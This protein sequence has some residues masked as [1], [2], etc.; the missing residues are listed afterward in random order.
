M[1]VQVSVLVV[2]FCSS[3]TSTQLVV[4]ATCEPTGS[5]Q[6]RG[7]GRHVVRYVEDPALRNTWAFF[8]DCDHPEGPGRLV[9]I[10]RTTPRVVN[11]IPVTTT[12]TNLQPRGIHAGETIT[13]VEDTPALH[14]ALQAVALEA[15]AQG[16]T[17]RVRL[18]KGGAVLLALILGPGRVVLLPQS[19]PFARTNGRLP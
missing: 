8:M 4:A 15:G 17:I 12:V 2:I 13:L 9:T 11:L 19:Q 5:K 3:F 7:V 18:L 6:I 10:D 14:L 16:G 1:R